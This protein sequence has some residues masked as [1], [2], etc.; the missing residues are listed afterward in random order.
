MHRILYILIAIVMLGFIVTMHEFGHYLVGRICGIGIV[1]FSIGM[2]PK[3]IGFKRKGI[4][5]SLRAIPLGGYCAF[6]GEDE[7]NHAENAMNNQPVWKRFLTVIAGP[8]MNFIL[9][10][11]FCVIMLMGCNIPEYQP[12]VS[13]IIDNTPAA[14]CGIEIDDVITHA[15]S[16]EISF[17]EAGITTLQNIILEN[18]TSAPIELTVERSGETIII[19][20]QPEEVI[21]NAET[22]Q[23]GYQL[24]ICFGYVERKCTFGEALGS[25]CRYMVDYT[26]EML[27]ALKN[28]IFKGEG[29][30]DMMGPVGIVSFTSETVA[31][32]KA[33]GAIT[34]IWFLSLSIGITNLLPLP[35]LD[36]GRL[37]FL[38]VEGIT[39][40]PIPREKEG[41]IHAIGLGLLLLLIVFITYKD[42]V[43]LITGG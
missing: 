21:I 16:K 27:A 13:E 2:G 23:T 22:G 39:R 25:S 6:V 43:R 33:S 41:L 15:N 18:G 28:L 30:E 3:I 7:E 14:A 5:Y 29:V 32:Q 1:E 19:P 8:V 31:T 17:D 38:I 10:F 35:A 34:L 37:I 20:V 36:G 40:K 12:K 26:K 24:G 11:I 42:I 9:A 4:Q